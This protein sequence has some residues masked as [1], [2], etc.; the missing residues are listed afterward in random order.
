MN[1]VT[2]TESITLA[3]EKFLYAANTLSWKK[4]KEEN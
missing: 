1:F 3:K 2:P 4:Y